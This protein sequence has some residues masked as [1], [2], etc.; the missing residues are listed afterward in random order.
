[1]KIAFA[2]AMVLLLLSGCTTAPNNESDRQS[3]VEESTG[4]LKQMKA[5]DAGLGQFLNHSYGYVIFP[6][7]GKGGLIAGGAYGRGIAF[8]QGK[9]I[10]YAD[11]SQATVGAQLGGQTYSEL[12]VFDA[13][14]DF[15]RFIGGRLT[16]SAN[17]SAV[18]IKTG[19]AEAARYTDGVAVFVEPTGGLMLE[20]AIGGQQF[21][22]TPR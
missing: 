20:A 9:M 17:V 4:A 10:G 16:F 21:T 13:Q 14:R 6:S 3:L 11:V 19:A 5:E 7:V 2:L 22:F 8:E 18:A 12:I 15:D 1:M